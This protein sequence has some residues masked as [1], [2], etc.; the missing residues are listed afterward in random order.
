MRQADE[1]VATELTGEKGIEVQGLN[2]TL[3]H[4]PEDVQ[5]A[6]NGRWVGH[7][8]TLMPFLR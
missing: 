3:L 6:T 1:L 5:I 7:F 2:T 8:G 4:E